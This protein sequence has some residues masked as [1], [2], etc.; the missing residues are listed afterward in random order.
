MSVG[1]PR[2]TANRDGA[3]AQWSQPEGQ[4]QGWRYEIA[5]WAIQEVEVIASRPGLR[6]RRVGVFVRGFRRNWVSV[7]Q[8]HDLDIRVKCD[9]VLPSQL[10]GGK[11]SREFGIVDASHGS[12]LFKSELQD[13]LAACIEGSF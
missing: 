13:A 2:L 4:V 10:P 5:P 8:D 1:E 12:A 9:D 6:S 11:A 3:R 7:R